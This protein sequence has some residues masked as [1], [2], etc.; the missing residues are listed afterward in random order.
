MRRKLSVNFIRVWFFEPVRVA[1]VTKAR[2]PVE[3]RGR[4]W[5]LGMGSRSEWVLTAGPSLPEAA[6]SP[7]KP[8]SAACRLCVP[9]RSLSLSIP[10]ANGITP[11]NTGE[12]LEKLNMK[13][14][15]V[16]SCSAN[17][18]ACYLQTVSCW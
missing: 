6:P 3:E 2:V 16:K 15:E 14:L 11:A 12:T 9:G 7:S 18:T 8:S 5:R 17:S 13:A 1:K 10:P 4:R